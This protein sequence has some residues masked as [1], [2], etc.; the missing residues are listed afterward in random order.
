MDLKHLKEFCWGH[1]EDAFCEVSFQLRRRRY[2]RTDNAQSSSDDL[3]A[4]QMAIT[5][6]SCSGELKIS[7]QSWV[8]IYTQLY[9]QIICC[10]L[11]KTANIET[12]RKPADHTNLIINWDIMCMNLMH[13]FYPILMSQLQ[14]ILWVTVSVQ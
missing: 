4:R 8:R 11:F 14:T 3:K 6:N 2:W 12:F 5:L 10:L 1:W 13:P 7:F 9:R